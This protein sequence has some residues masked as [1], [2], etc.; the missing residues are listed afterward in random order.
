VAYRADDSYG[1]DGEAY[2][3]DEEEPRRGLLSWILIV[4]LLMG[5]GSGSALLWRTFA[6]GPIIAS[7]TSTASAEKPSGQGDLEA[8]RQQITGSVQSTQHCWRRSRRKSN[9]C[10]TRSRRYQ[11]NSNCCSGRL[12]RPRPQCRQLLRQR[13]WR[14]RRRKSPMSQSRSRRSRANSSRPPPVRSRPAARRCHLAAEA[15]CAGRINGRESSCRLRA[16]ITRV[17]FAA[18]DQPRA[19]ASKLEQSSTRLAIVNARKLPET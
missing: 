16:R 1:V 17:M 9:G 10:R 19:K 3:V 12:P 13:R 8:I 5:T 7:P 4:A 2:D 18:T 6:G 11:E 15:G 14:L